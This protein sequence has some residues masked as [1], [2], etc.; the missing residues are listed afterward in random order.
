MNDLSA[1]RRKEIDDNGDYWRRWN[2]FLTL[3]DKE[4]SVPN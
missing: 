4:K 2:T 1:T 3:V